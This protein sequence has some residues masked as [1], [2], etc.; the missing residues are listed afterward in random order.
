MRASTDTFSYAMKAGTL[1]VKFDNSVWARDGADG[2]QTVIAG[3]NGVAFHFTE[4]SD[5]NRNLLKYEIAV[6]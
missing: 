4:T 6:P 5:A 2:R 3:E 1:G